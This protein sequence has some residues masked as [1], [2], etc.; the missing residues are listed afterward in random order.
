MDLSDLSEQD[1]NILYSKPNNYKNFKYISHGW[2]G[3]VYKFNDYAIKISKIKTNDNDKIK[4]NNNYINRTSLSNEEIE[5]NEII[6]KNNPTN[7]IKIYDILYKYNFIILILEYYDGNLYDIINDLE[8]CDIYFILLQIHIA[9]IELKKLNIYHND[10]TRS[11]ILYKKYNTKQK[12]NYMYNNKLYKIQTKYIIAITDFGKSK[13]NSKYNNNLYN[14]SIAPKRLLVDYI[15]D[16]FALDELNNK[17]NLN[18]TDKKLL[19]YNLIEKK[20][21][22][23]PIIT[24]T[25]IDAFNL[26][27]DNNIN[28][29]NKLTK[30]CITNDI[31]INF[32]KQDLDNIYNNFKD[33]EKFKYI[34]SGWQ[35]NVYKYEDKYAIKISKINVNQ[36][37]KIKL[38]N[39]TV[40]TRIPFRSDEIKINN[41]LLNIDYTNIIKIYNMYE[42]ENYIITIMEL[43]DGNLYD[44]IKNLSECEI[45]NAFFQIVIAVYNLQQLNITHNDLNI[46]NILYKYYKEKQEYKIVINNKIYKFLTNYIFIIT[47]F[48][49]A[50]IY[51][52]SISSKISK[53]IDKNSD[54]YNLYIYPKKIII[55]YIEQ[56]FNIHELYKLGNNDEHFKTYYKEQINRINKNNKNKIIHN[57][58]YYL[59]EKK[60]IKLQDIP[61]ALSQN[62]ID[63]TDTF[64]HDDILDVINNLYNNLCQ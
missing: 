62:I 61:T 14:I 9:I 31:Y 12:L 28:T 19:I 63:L 21:I 5:I 43:C 56:K 60:L 37:N 30:S 50:K 35:G 4:I 41:V 36:T 55:E 23:N 26:L 25:I 11:N 34:S 29:I 58:I 64:I 20:L 3:N 47:D 42:Q 8:F 32:T 18:Y 15:N 59:I 1:L 53:Y 45:I 17:Y 13:L 38:K 57:L 33:Y 51:D 16:K 24:Y 49:K 48:G 44:L 27:N 39:N 22:D 40:I 46:T 52:T 6:K 2:Q 54:L 10:L 7:I